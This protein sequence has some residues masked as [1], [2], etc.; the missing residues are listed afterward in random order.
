MDHQ[1]GLSIIAQ[2]GAQDTRE[3]EV[4]TMGFNNKGNYLVQDFCNICLCYEGRFLAQTHPGAPS[5]PGQDGSVPI[6]PAP[7]SQ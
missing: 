4:N 6:D 3:Q 7:V 5:D 2:A 1:P